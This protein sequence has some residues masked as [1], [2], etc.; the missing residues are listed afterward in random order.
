MSDLRQAPE[1][2]ERLDIKVRFQYGTYTTRT[3][4]GQRA[5]STA[6]S[7]DAARLLCKKLLGLTSA[8]GELVHL[9]AKRWPIAGE[10]CFD[11][12]LRHAVQQPNEVSP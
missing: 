10:C 1:S 11:V 3:V 8:G 6:S 2:L 7:E 5:S 12:I 4:R 9:R